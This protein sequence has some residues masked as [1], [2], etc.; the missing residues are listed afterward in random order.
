MGLG[1]AGPTPWTITAAGGVTGSTTVLMVCQQRP[2]N[3][4]I[5]ASRGSDGPST[6]AVP[7]RPA[8]ARAPRVGSPRAARRVDERPAS[9]PICSARSPSRERCWSASS[10][11]GT[12]NQLPGGAQA[13]P[14]GVRSPQFDA[15]TS[16]HS[17]SPGVANGQNAP[18]TKSRR[19]TVRRRS[20]TWLSRTRHGAGAFS[21]RLAPSRRR[22]TRRPCEKSA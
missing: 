20:A 12:A 3:G 6:G 13:D 17:L 11:R 5:S 4:R 21:R 15:S 8:A 14:R 22:G 1:P 16:S 7:H 2:A 10:A 19:P 9:I 18:R